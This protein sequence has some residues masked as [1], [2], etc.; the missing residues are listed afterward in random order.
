MSPAEALE[1]LT[2]LQA[3]VGLLGTLEPGTERAAL[4]RAS[5][6]RRIAALREHLIATIPLAPREVNHG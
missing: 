4:M 2:Q 6:Q 1:T 3:E 5:C